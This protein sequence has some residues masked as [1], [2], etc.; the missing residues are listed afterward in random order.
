MQ[1]DETYLKDYGLSN[2][3]YIHLQKLQAEAQDVAYKL[4]SSCTEKSRQVTEVA[5]ANQQL[6]EEFQSKQEELKKLVEQHKNRKQEANCGM[7]ELIKTM[8]QKAKELNKECSQIQKKFKKGEI[9]ADEYIK[10][11][12]AAKMKHSQAMYTQRALEIK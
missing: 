10:Q 12:K 8:N 3:K 2:P 1:E 6:V 7:S 11:F 9:T 4:A 5:E